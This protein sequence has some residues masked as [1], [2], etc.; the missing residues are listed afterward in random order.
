MSDD[1][2]IVRKGALNRLILNRPKALHALNEAMCRTMNA[3]LADWAA[4]DAGAVLVTHAEG[5]RGFCA[6]GDIRMLADSGAGDGA[7]AAAF[8][9]EEYRLN[10]RI[11]EYPHPY[12]AILD[13]VTMGGGVGISVHGDVRIAT[14]N[15]TFAMP[16]T[17]IGLFPD[18]GGSWFLPRLDG[19]LGTW[20]ALTGRRL[21]GRDVFAAG[22]ATHFILS[23]NLPDLIAALEA[24][25]EADPSADPTQ[26]LLEH[27]ELTP[28]AAFERPTFGPFRQA[29]DACFAYDT[30]EEIFAVLSE[31]ASDWATGTLADLK[32]KSPQ[33]IKV[34][35]R[36]MREGA[37][38]DRFRDVMTMEYR[39]ARRVVSRHDFLEGVRAVIV[40]KDNA[41]KWD[42]ARIE[43]VPD[44]L[45][46]AIFAPLPEGEEWTP[47]PMP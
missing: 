16:E 26:T 1:A 27:C 44:D 36:Q 23:E 43:D 14:E 5:S 6:G 46:E 25:F 41:P 39:I 9:A 32:T 18:V 20:L 2:V 30:A 34:A 42:P 19:R 12:I 31:N 47:P 15:T 17:G 33:T 8:F 3:A 11:H 29:I 38:M 28:A 35:L 40:D 7:A 24:L 21:K 4:Q 37:R 10:T 45:I 22:V 13:G